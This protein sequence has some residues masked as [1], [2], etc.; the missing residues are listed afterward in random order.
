MAH[1]ILIAG[2]G[3]LG[4]RYL[5]GLACVV[6]TLDIWV[7]DISI[8]ALTISKNR[9]NEVVNSA[10]HSVQYI[11]DLE[12]IP[13]KIEL[14]IITTTS[15]VRV[16]V[17]LK[18]LKKTQ[19]NKW[20]LE[21]VLAQKESDLIELETQ[22]N[23][24]HMAWVNTPRYIWPLYKKLRDHYPYKKSI[25]VIF[26]GINGLACNSIHYIDLV[27]RW[28]CTSVTS[29]DTSGL[30]TEWYPSKRVGFFDIN[31]IITV[32]FEDGSLLKI[33]SFCNNPTSQGIFRTNG[34]QWIISESVG[35]AI[36]IDGQIIEGIS[37]L[38]TQLTSL[39]VQDIINNKPCGLPLLSESV[40]QHKIFLQ[41]LLNHW[42][43]YMKTNLDYVPIT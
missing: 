1:S 16:D 36:S 26:E 17:V 7:F 35:R 23:N 5:Q 19:V 9:W 43:K 20:L 34:N 6:E 32:N 2:A 28:N 39:I 31:G 27:S 8:N 11:T 15:D 29:I 18:I 22:L 24:K 4:S 21:K 37:L 41:E 33:S 40:R 14:A 10:K 30:E 13:N 42:N 3:Q 38:Q 25:E 12:H